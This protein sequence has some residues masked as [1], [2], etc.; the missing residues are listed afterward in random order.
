[1]AIEYWPILG[2][3]I[4]LT[5]ETINFE[6]ATKTM[7]AYQYLNPDIFDADPD[8]ITIEDVLQFLAEIA[9]IPLY[10]STTGYCCGTGYLYLPATLP[11][12]DFGKDVTKDYAEKVFVYLAN[13]VLADNCEV[14]PEEVA[15]VGCG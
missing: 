12:D 8:E 10:W 5:E 1:M 13:L 6:K 15:D 9:P 2:Y 4:G 11:W 3:G 7:Q 14:C